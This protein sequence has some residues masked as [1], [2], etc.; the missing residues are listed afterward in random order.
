MTIVTLNRQIVKNIRTFGHFWEEFNTLVKKGI[1]KKISFMLIK[2]NVNK[3][4][5]KN[6]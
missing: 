1:D 5:R 2:F 3:I 6:N 4:D